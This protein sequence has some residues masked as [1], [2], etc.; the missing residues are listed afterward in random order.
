MPVAVKRWGKLWQLW[1]SGLR[2]ARISDTDWQ[3][4]R[5]GAKSVLPSYHEEIDA[6]EK[7]PVAFLVK[8]GSIH[9]TQSAMLTGEKTS[10][11]DT[12]YSAVIGL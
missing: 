3:S 1:A 8:L 2:N 12:N 11:A 5:S 9:I 6:E 10:K 7:K 4:R